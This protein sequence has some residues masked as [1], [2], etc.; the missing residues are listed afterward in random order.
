MKYPAVSNVLTRVL[1]RRYEGSLTLPGELQVLS[2]GAGNH[3][4]SHVETSQSTKT[5]CDRAG[6]GSIVNAALGSGQ[7]GL[8]K[9]LRVLPYG[10][11]LLHG[12]TDYL[13]GFLGP[14]AAAQGFDGKLTPAIQSPSQLLA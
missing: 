14:R 12:D 3:I 4:P 8:P 9:T 10:D 13:T 2:E 11:H 1:F 6:I 7:P 5:P